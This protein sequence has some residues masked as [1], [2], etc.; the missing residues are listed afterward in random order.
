MDCAEILAIH[1]E[2]VLPG[3]VPVNIKNLEK[4][5]QAMEKVRSL[6]TNH[7]LLGNETVLEGEALNTLFKPDESRKPPE[8]GMTAE[9]KMTA[10]QFPQN[11]VKRFIQH[12]WPHSPKEYMAWITGSIVKE[13]VPGTKGKDVK[14]QEISVATGLFFPK[15]SSTNTCVFEMGDSGS[16]VKFCEGSASTVVGWIH[17]HPTFEAFLSSIDCHMQQQIQKDVPL[18][19]ALVVD[20]NK[21]FRCM[22]LTQAGMDAVANCK[23]SCTDSWLV[24]GG[25]KGFILGRQTC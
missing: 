13:K 19:Y 11:L 21:D 25:G 3:E 2:E 8:K 6:A 24:W 23:L 14:F 18:A 20:Q 10:I 12:A 16:V 9:D 1:F 7:K 4:S 15:Q 22:R 5:T 17:S